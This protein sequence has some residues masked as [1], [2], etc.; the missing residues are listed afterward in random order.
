VGRDAQLT[1][2]ASA[3]DA[4]MRGETRIVYVSGRSGAGKS[5]LIERFLSDVR[6]DEHVLVLSGRCD[7]QESVPFKAVDPLIDAL[8]RWLRRQSPNDIRRILPPDVAVLRRLFPVL[9]RVDVVADAP[10][11]SLAV[12]DARELRRHAF[13]ALREI[14]TRI[15]ETTPVVMVIDDL[16]WGDAESAEL[17]ADLLD[18]PPFARMLV[19][20]AFR[21]EYRETSAFLHTLGTELG[22]RRNGAASD[23]LEVTALETSDARSLA[24]LLLG[25]SSESVVARVADE[26][27]GNPFFIHE[28]ARYVRD[29]PQW[30]DD[31]PSEVLDLDRVLWSRI[32]ALPSPAKELLEIIA[33]AGR[34][35]RNRHWHGASPHAAQ[36]PRALALL[37]YEHLLRSAGAAPDDEVE[38]YHD[39]VRETIVARLDPATRKVHHRRLAISLAGDGDPETVAA[40]FAEAGERERAGEHFGR[41]AQ[42]A[43]QALAFDRAASLYERALEYRTVDPP[44]R[45]RMLIALG[46]ALANAGRGLLAADAYAR[47]AALAE[48]NERLDL[49]RI[50][51]TQYVTSGHIDQG[52]A[53]FLRVLRGVGISSPQSSAALTAQ[54]LGRRA[55]LR[56]RGLRFVERAERDVPPRLLRRLDAL[57]A[58]ST[59]LA[60]VEVVRVAAIQSQALL[61]ALDAGEPHRLALGLAWEAVLTAT[62]GSRSARRS[63]KLLR[64]ARTLAL[65]VE[66]PQASGMMHLAEG[67]VAFLHGRFSDALAACAQAEPIFRDQCTGVW[68]EL[69]TTRTMIAWAT[70]HR[71]DNTELATQIRAWEVEARAHGNHFM[72]T[73]LLAFPLPYERLIADDVV[74]ADAFLVEALAL[75]PYAGFHIQHVSVLFSRALMLLYRGDGAEACAEVTRQWPAMVRSLQTRNQV[76]RVMLRDVRARGALAA[77]AAGIDRDRHLARAARDARLIERE[78]SPWTAGYVARLEAGLAAVRGEP[79]RAER[80]LRVAHA[81][82]DSS[83]LLLQGAA[84]RRQLGMLIGGD[85]GRQ[86]ADSASALMR[87][88][89]V[90]NVD[91]TTR[92]LGVGLA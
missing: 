55:W 82:L 86:L 48:G 50:A 33:I 20:A 9:E 60:P 78:G 13:R 5:A 10:R 1:Q 40:H 28:L 46:S 26:S 34:P 30:A 15:S 53:L 54:L 18:G 59:A 73:N 74:G 89:Q 39:R 41:A 87:D 62:A 91:A 2:L 75:W 27:G 43:A 52:R 8:A 68:W 22:S 69:C 83:G 65:K 66:H 44:E 88:R 67:W 49:E 51:A 4:T 61:L 23:S 64:L 21:S 47:A 14:F 38:P 31:A 17:L 90:V 76:T 6:H 72:V 11:G 12:P 16:Q 19:V 24:R 84:A 80:G 56:V 57:W 79:E 42:I 70:A 45:R 32:Q 35:V 63:G 85:E 37:R 25:D 58:V 77:A 71:G 7:E 29:H 81:A 36:D 92:M 3:L